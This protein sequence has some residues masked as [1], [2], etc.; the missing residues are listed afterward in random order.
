[1]TLTKGLFTAVVLLLASCVIAQE[2]ELSAEEQQYL[3]EAQQLWDSLNKQ[4][5]EIT[6]PGGIAQLAV[7]ENFYYLD[8]ND[9]K[10]V[11]V[12]VWGNPPENAYGLLGM[13]FPAGSTPFDDDS[14]GVTIEYEQDGYVSDKDADDINYDKLLKQMKKDTRAANEERVELGYEPIELVGWAASPYYDEANHQL[15]WA[16]EIRFGDYDVNTL[17]YNIRVL[18]RQGV[19]VMNFIAGMNQ[20]DEINQNLDEVLQLAQF[21]QGQRYEDFDPSI[22]E[23]AA[24]GLGALVAGKLVA[25]TGL[26]AAA[27][28]FL[29]KFGV[30]ILIALGAVFSKLFR[31]K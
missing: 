20:L 6:L 13:I 27:L 19:L 18:G 25:K 29:K 3:Q 11:L 30:V 17:N 28:I 8:P 23:V 21:N 24:Y 16:K 26:I 10:T 14:W 12:D 7:T 2:P 4:T 31:R 5:G 1:M 9:A 15:Y 22:D